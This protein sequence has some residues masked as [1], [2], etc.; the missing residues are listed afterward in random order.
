M[1][2]SS[3]TGTITYTT[4]IKHKSCFDDVSLGFSANVILAFG[5]E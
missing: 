4:V 5:R 3:G 1:L 2:W